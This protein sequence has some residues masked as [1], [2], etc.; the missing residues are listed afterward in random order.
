MV[1]TVFLSGNVVIP[2]GNHILPLAAGIFYV[3]IIVWG[4]L[5]AFLCRND[6]KNKSKNQMKKTTAKSLKSCSRTIEP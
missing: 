3:Y 6:R 4:C 2:E 1:I 5:V